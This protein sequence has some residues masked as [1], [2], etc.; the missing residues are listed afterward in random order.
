MPGAAS[1][2]SGGGMPVA[3]AREPWLLAWYP[4]LPMHRAQGPSQMLSVPPWFD[5][6]LVKTAVAC[7]NFSPYAIASTFTG[8]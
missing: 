5:C 8:W 4:T 1:S 3:K 6:S 7:Q 2:A